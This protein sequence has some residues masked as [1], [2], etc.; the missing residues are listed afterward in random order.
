[1]AEIEGLT[2]P[3]D[4]PDGGPVQVPEIDIL[5]LDRAT[6]IAASVQYILQAYTKLYEMNVNNHRN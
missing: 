4:P 6:A 1:M 5:K 3:D 2:P